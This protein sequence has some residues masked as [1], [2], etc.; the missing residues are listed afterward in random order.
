MKL[1][2]QV[3]LG[4]CCGITTTVIFV[5]LAETEIIGIFIWVFSFKVV[6]K[7]CNLYL[8]KP[9]ITAFVAMITMVLAILLVIFIDIFSILDGII[10]DIILPYEI[11]TGN[12]KDTEKEMNENKVP[13]D[14]VV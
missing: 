5:R 4:F 13:V 7:L 11:L 12:D 6:R 3:L 2:I 9:G 14:D 1:K 8:Y 10:V